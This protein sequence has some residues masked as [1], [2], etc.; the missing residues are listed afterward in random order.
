MSTQTVKRPKRGLG[1]WA[2][3]DLL[4]MTAIAIAFGLIL[5]GVNYLG[6]GL[7]AIN[8][9]FAS[10]FAGLYYLA[11]LM[12]M[13]IVRRPGANILT[14]VIVNLAMLPFTPFGW[15]PLILEP[16]FFGGA[17]ELP[18]LI[19]RY[20]NFRM[21]IAVFGGMAAGLVSF[22]LMWAF[23]LFS[24]LAA[25]LMIAALGIFLLSGALLGGVL[26][27]VLVNAIAKTGVL[28]SFAIAET[29][30]EEI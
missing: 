24:G 29:Q 17:A 15:A 12:V 14:R 13:L 6:V 2:T 5:A 20:R 27:T 18:F 23:G 9:L 3:R 1:G 4:V 11:G 22:L 8:P 26:A 16:L 25:V 28:N 19:T 30:Q 21:H 10:V 7:M